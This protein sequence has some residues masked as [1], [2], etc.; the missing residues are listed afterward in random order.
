MDME[1][2]DLI[3]FSKFL[4]FVDTDE[5][6]FIDW[7]ND[8]SFSRYVRAH[9]GEIKKECEAF[10]YQ[11]VYLPEVA[12]SLL[13]SMSEEQKRYY[14]PGGWDVEGGSDLLLAFCEEEDKPKY[15]AA[16]L[17]CNPLMYRAERTVLKPLEE[18][19]FEEQ[20]RAVLEKM[21]GEDEP[22]P[23]I[24]E[25]LID[26]MVGPAKF[27][28]PDFEFIPED[29]PLFSVRKKRGTEVDGAR[30]GI[31]PR[32]EGRNVRFSISDFYRKKEYDAD[33]AFSDEA[34]RLMDEVR[35]RVDQLRLHG[36]DEEILL[37]LLGRQERLSR[38]VVTK[39]FR[40]LLPDYDEMEIEMGALPKALFLLFLRHEEGIP[41]RLLVDYKEELREIYGRISDRT[42]GVAD[43]SLEAICDQ[44][45]NAI[46]VNCS[47][48]RSAFV[49]RFDDRLAR[50]YY[51]TG[52]RG[53]PKGIALPRELVEWEM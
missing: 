23:E 48:I 53:E 40:I 9:L 12:Q 13:G 42:D 20:L 47:R 52:E 11:F 7:D 27:E 43:R 17:R 51:I 45:N 15:V 3:R 50:H 39:D 18:V 28:E 35:E 37:G 24:E 36:V 31:S 26:L 49:G 4:E 1:K 16:L 38:L 14:M 46:N 30:F 33:E 25:C 6:V 34:R 22:K 29:E 32:E 44:T 19:A 8:S 5:V 21:R 41:F 10:G 2:K